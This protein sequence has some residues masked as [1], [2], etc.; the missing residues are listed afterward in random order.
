MEAAIP[1]TMIMYKGVGSKT[2]PGVH[3]M[4]S[5]ALM[6]VLLLFTCNRQL[7]PVAKQRALNLA[8]GLIQLG[9]KTLSISEVFTGEIYVKDKGYFYEQLSVDCTTGLVIGFAELLQKHPGA[10]WA[11]G[12]LMANAFCPVK[13]TSSSSMPTLWDLVILLAW[14]KNN[15]ATKNIWK[16]FGQL[17]W[18]HVLWVVGKVLDSLAME[19]SNR[20]LEQLPLL[21]TPL[22]KTKKI[23]G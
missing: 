6:L 13:I 18:P 1:Q 3:C 2:F 14:A 12:H 17:L 10:L 21:K 5:S 22:G 8:I 15:K 4:G 16:T 11:W 19:R 9:V 20:P 7:A 23:T